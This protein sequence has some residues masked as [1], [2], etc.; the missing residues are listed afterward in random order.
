ME[1]SPE[2]VNAPDESGVDPTD[3][4]DPW[5]WLHED[6]TPVHLDLSGERVT[7]VLVTRNGE[8]WLAE[9]LAGLGAQSMPIQRAIAVDNQSSDGSAALLAEALDR[10]DLTDVVTG[11]N[12]WGFGEAVAAALSDAPADG[13]AAHDSGDH[14]SADADLDALARGTGAADPEHPGWIWL[15]HD[16]AVASP[17]ALEHLLDCALAQDATVVGAKLLQA[18]RRG[19]KAVSELGVT[20]SGSGARRL[21]AEQGEPDQGQF[22]SRTVLGVSTCGMLVRRDVWDRLGGLSASIPLFRDGVEFG[23]RANLAGE[24]VV[25][26]PD[27]EI[28]HRQAGRAGLRSGLAGSPTA[29]DTRYGMMVASAHR[30]WPWSWIAGVGMVIAG[31]LRGLGFLLGKAPGRALDEIRGVGSYIA[32]VGAI[33]Q[34]RRRVFAIHPSEEAKARVKNLRPKRSAGLQR[35]WES[36]AGAVSDATT[37]VLGTRDEAMLDDLT[38]D[39]FAGGGFEAPKRRR[40]W[41]LSTVIVFVVVTVAALVAGRDLLGPGRLVS[42]QLLAAPDSFVEMWRSYLDAVPGV[43]QVAAPPWVGI[44]AVLSTLTFGQ[45]EL[46]VRI[47]VVGNVPLAML[48]CFWFLRRVLRDRRSQLVGAL[49]Y[50]LVPV[51]IGAST[52]GQLGVLVWA[53]ALPLLGMAVFAW[54]RRGTQ[55]ADSWRGPFATGLVLTVLAAFTPAILPLAVVA[56]IAAIAV[57]RRG[58]Q[59]IRVLVALVVPVALLAPWIPTLIRFPG[60]LLTSEEPILGDSAAPSTL[61]LLLGRTPGAG[62]P[63]VWLSVVVMAGLALMVLVGLAL[64][65]RRSVPWAGAGIVS[66]AVAVGV[67][68]VL[69]AVPEAGVAVRPSAGPWLLLAAAALI[70]AAGTGWD[71]V[72]GQL[73]RESFGAKQALAAAALIAVTATTL[74]GAGW[75]VVG[76]QGSPAHRVENLQPLYVQA[77]QQPPASVRTLAIDLRGGSVGYTVVEG[78][79]PTWGDSERGAGL[80][81]PADQA[82]VRQ[83][84]GELVLGRSDQ[85]VADAITRL[86]FG[87]VQ[88]RGASNDQGAQISAVPGLSNATGEGD[89]RVW[90]VLANRGRAMV[91]DPGGATRVIDPGGTRIPDGPAGRQ[92]VL[93]E[94]PDARWRVTLDG[95]ALTPVSG[96]LDPRPRYDVGATGGELRYELQAT[97]WWAW[98]QL[99]GLIVVAV[100]A[101]PSLRRPQMRDPAL[102]ARRVAEVD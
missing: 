87:F 38:G 100:A 31:V 68:R 73:A 14:D 90:R 75:W 54:Q 77:A 26:C 50:A 35:M 39:D 93:S 29:Q 40:P 57:W 95:R 85:A 28:T 61:S 102:Y 36:A 34:L 101:A 3:N 15:L 32:S 9:A 58:A 11:K 46:A 69:V 42:A 52:R 23:W 82:A 60:R 63:P 89:L 10:G 30:R 16:D 64:R 56:G 53:I 94:R 19:A 33:G 97:P 17:T 8:E 84:V 71:T 74:I 92:F 37:G 48:T 12:S 6:E 59:V 98:L 27:A 91:V 55:G 21:V 79:G 83:L 25:T 2:S 66:L 81:S 44:M 24:K 7:A 96:G 72:A 45:P 62:L 70:M 80:T 65:P 51:L 99:A 88:V 1:Q 67:T 78:G 41:A 20:I 86:G 49:L 13:S 22:D 47:L 5:A 4:L 76:G 18:R 43:P